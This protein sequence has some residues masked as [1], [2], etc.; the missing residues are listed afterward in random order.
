MW[1]LMENGQESMMVCWLPVLWVAGAFG[2]CSELLWLL[3]HVG[4]WKSLYCLL[5][6]LCVWP[7][8]SFQTALRN[9][10]RMFCTDRIMAQTTTTRC[11]ICW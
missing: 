6:L 9:S 2:C 10:C 11:T 7:A 8:V 5:P 1:P 4:R 3:C